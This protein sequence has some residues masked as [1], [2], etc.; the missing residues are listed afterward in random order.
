MQILEPMQMFK[1]CIS[2]YKDIVKLH[3]SKESMQ[4]VRNTLVNRYHK[5]C[6]IPGTQSFYQFTPQSTSILAIKRSCKAETINSV[7]ELGG[8]VWWKMKMRNSN[9]FKLYWCTLMALQGLLISHS[10]VINILY[11]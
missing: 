7:F 11:I 2:H 10:L 4:E 1:F 5:L 3:V 6:T 9:I 8:L